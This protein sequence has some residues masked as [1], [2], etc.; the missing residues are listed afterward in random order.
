MWWCVWT[1][2]VCVQGSVSSRDVVVV[3][4]SWPVD[5]APATVHVLSLRAAAAHLPDAADLAAFPGPLV[6]GTRPRSPRAP[7]ARPYGPF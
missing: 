6:R 1:D 2:N 3:R 4:P 7:R 5:G